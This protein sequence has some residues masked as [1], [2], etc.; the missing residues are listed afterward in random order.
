MAKERQQTPKST[1]N[2]MPQPN[3]SQIVG[4]AQNV[5][6]DSPG[7]ETRPIITA[8]MLSPDPPPSNSSNSQDAQPQAS[9][10]QPDNEGN[11]A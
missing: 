10:V 5:N 2:D 8:E 3:D 7:I 9:N 4:Q 6:I 11:D 1:E